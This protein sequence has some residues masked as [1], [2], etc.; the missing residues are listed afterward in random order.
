MNEIIGFLLKVNPRDRPNCDE[1]LK[2]PLIKKRL[3]FFQA[4]AGENESMMDNIDEGVLLRTIRIPK[5]IIFLSDN[6]PEKN[7]EKSKSHTKALGRNIR[8]LTTNTQNNNKYS[9]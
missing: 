5:N 2:H 4:Q 1:I 6:L 9:K 8:K 7:Y 3:E